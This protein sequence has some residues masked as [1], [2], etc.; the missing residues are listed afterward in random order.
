MSFEIAIVPTRPSDLDWVPKLRH[1]L[2][3]NGALLQKLRIDVSVK[4]IATPNDAL[5]W[6]AESP[7]GRLMLIFGGRDDVNSLVN[8]DFHSGG[9][10]IVGDRSNRQHAVNGTTASVVDKDDC[11]SIY[12]KITTRIRKSLIRAAIQQKQ[13]D[14]RTPSSPSELSGYFS[15]RYRVWDEMGYLRQENKRIQKK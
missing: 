1:W 12:N 8:F 14:I 6:L 13:I 7:G 4:S 15:L 9:R 10:I 3:L 11:I 2:E 5:D